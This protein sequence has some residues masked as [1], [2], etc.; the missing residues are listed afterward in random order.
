MKVQANMTPNGKKDTV[1]TAGSI[2]RQLEELTAQLMQRKIDNAQYMSRIAE[3]N[4]RLDL[5]R[6]ASKLK[7]NR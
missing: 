6:I 1:R 3:I 5:R 2:E 4:P 7:T